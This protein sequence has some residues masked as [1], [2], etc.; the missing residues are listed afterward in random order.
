MAC[1][2]FVFV[3]F[4]P[5]P[6]APCSATHPLDNYSALVIYPA[7]IKNGENILTLI[8]H[9]GCFHFLMRSRYSSHLNHYCSVFLLVNSNYH[10]NSEPFK[11]PI[12]ERHF[13]L[14]FLSA[15]KHLDTF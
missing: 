6:M 2:S 5:P 7:T 11:I 10:F 12:T 14:L 8:E 4:L 15:C 13:D 1:N 9:M 3:D